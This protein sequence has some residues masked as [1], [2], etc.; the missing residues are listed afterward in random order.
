MKHEIAERISV[1]NFSGPLNLRE[2]KAICSIGDGLPKW[3]QA[4]IVVSLNASPW[5]SPAGKSPY[6]Q[7]CL[8][9]N[10]PYS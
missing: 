6:L 9:I 5:V 2:A 8:Q 4:H 10:S 7:G 1:T 3:E